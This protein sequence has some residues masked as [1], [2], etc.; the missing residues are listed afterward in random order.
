MDILSVPYHRIQAKKPDRFARGWHCFG[1]V[2]DFVE[3]ITPVECFGTKLVIWRGE[4]GELRAFDA[5]CPHMG[6]DLSLGKVIGNRLACPFHTWQWGDGGFCEHIPYSNSIPKKARIRQWHTMVENNLLF[7]WHDQEE[8]PPIAEQIIPPHRCC[9]EDGWSDWVILSRVAHSN[10]R[11]LIDNL[12]DVSH[13]SPVH[14]SPV[15]SYINASEAHTYCQMLSGGNQL[16][17][18]GDTLK[19]VAY[20]YGPAYVIADLIGDM[21]GHK[22]ESIMMIGSVPITHEKFTM[23]FGMK[24][25]R[26]PTLSDAQN[27]KLIKEYIENGQET[28][29]QDLKIWDTKV[30]VDNPIL[31][32][33]DG[34]VYKLREWYRQFY[35]DIADVDPSLR[36]KR[37][38]VSRWKT[39]GSTSAWIREEHGMDWEVPKNKKA[40]PVY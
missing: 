6:A 38:Y 37:I 15:S 23:H 26:V 28:F 27:E 33:A 4:D 9:N 25:R 17:G 21:W 20:Y 32:E 1:A 12:A 11:E 5:F 40:N 39:D 13:F 34:P 7:V 35:V 36:Q 18:E 8:N 10:C 3:P 31:C 16:I 24:V 2:K 30:T 29:Y 19:S 22:I 14:G